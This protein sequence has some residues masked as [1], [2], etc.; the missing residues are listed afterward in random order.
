VVEPSRDQLPDEAYVVRGGRMESSALW[1]NARDHNYEFPDE[2]AISVSSGTGWSPDEIARAAPFR[3]R[4][5]RVSTVGA[6]RLLGHDVI[7][8]DEPPHADLVLACEPTEDIWEALREAFQLPVPN[9]RYH[10][11]V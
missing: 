8:S 7:V 4:E 2:W 11:E 10:E 6:V 1:T 3:N 5:M 9:P